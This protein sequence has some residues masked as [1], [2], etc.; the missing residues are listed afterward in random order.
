MRVR[1]SRSSASFKIVDLQVSFSRV[2][3][4]IVICP[5]ISPLGPMCFYFGGPSI[6]LKKPVL[7]S[8]MFK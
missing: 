8:G 3:F 2:S 6:L 1:F 5:L 4:C 7:I